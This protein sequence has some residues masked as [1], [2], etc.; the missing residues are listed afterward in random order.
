LITLTG[1]YMTFAKWADVFGRLQRRD[2]H[3]DIDP[4]IADAAVYSQE[5]HNIV[6][7]TFSISYVFVKKGRLLPNAVKSQF[8]QTVSFRQEAHMRGALEI[9]PRG[10]RSLHDDTLPARKDL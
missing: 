1:F 6:F 8:L 9:E 3:A 5:W 7:L 4:S 10:Y 2:A